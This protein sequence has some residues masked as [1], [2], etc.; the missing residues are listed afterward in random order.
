MLSS[1]GVQFDVVPSDYVEDMSLSME[2]KKLAM[3]LSKGK[4]DTVAR[5]HSD[6]VVIAADTFIVC[7]GEILGKPHTADKARDM[8]NKLSDK[9]HSVLTGFT[10]VDSENHFELTKAVES[11]VF[12]KKLTSEEVESY[13]ATGEP[14]DKAG[15]YGIQGL[16]S[17]FVEKI[18]GSYSNI[19]G[20]PVEE[21]K[22]VLKNLG[23]LA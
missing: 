5:L 1:L 8:L 6:T 13:I 10:V 3:H 21:I 20:L 2:P 19:V 22:N 4:A 14:L 23:F 12:F 7:D 9:V 16:A 18:E 15:A 17:K 11:K